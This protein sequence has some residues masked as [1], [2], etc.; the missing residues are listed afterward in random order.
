MVRI[1]SSPFSLSLSPSCARKRSPLRPSHA[2][3]TS[4][5]L[6]SSAPRPEPLD[7][8][9]VT[10]YLSQAQ[11]RVK[12][13][14]GPPFGRS[15]ASPAAV[16]HRQPS[17]A[18]PPYCPIRLEPSDLNPTI[19]IGSNPSQTSRYRSVLLLLQKS[20]PSILKSTRGTFALKNIYCLVQLFTHSPLSFHS[21]ETAVLSWSPRTFYVLALEVYG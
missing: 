6:R 21:F 2:S 1:L 16:R 17:Q 15:P 18:P 14:P 3:P 13:S 12:P 10:R 4:A 20:P 7:A 9:P 5:A 11:N 8:F 19:Q